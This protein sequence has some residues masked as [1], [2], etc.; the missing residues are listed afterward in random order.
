MRRVVAVMIMVWL[1]WAGSAVASSVGG[2]RVYSTRLPAEGNEALLGVA[3]SADG[4]V[5]V[6]DQADDS[7]IAIAPNG[8]RRLVSLGRGALRDIADRN[9]DV[10]AVGAVYVAPDGSVYVGERGAL[11]RVTAGA[12]QTVRIPSGDYASPGAFALGSDGALWFTEVN[13]PDIGRFDPSTA[14]ITEFADGTGGHRRPA[15]GIA[16]GPDGR[17][18]YT[19]PSYDNDVRGALGAMTTG[20]A[21]RVYRPEVKGLLESAE[22]IVADGGSLWVLGSRFGQAP[23]GQ[24]QSAL[25]RVTPGAGAPAV[26]RV[27]PGLADAAGNLGLAPS[28]TLYAV[29]GALGASG[30]IVSITERGAA[31]HFGHANGQVSLFGSGA[32]TPGVAAAPDGSAWLAADDG[33]LEH[34]VPGAPEPCVVPRVLGYKSAAAKA[35]LRRARCE[36][37]IGTVDGPSDTPAIV[38]AQRTRP[39]TVLAPG[40]PVK[41]TVR[42]GV[43]YACDLTGDG[44]PIL[45]VLRATC[46]SARHLFHVVYNRATTRGTARAD[47]FICRY[48]KRTAIP[49]MGGGEVDCRARNRRHALRLVQMFW[50]PPR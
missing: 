2:G 16:S 14:R 18:W 42:R 48:D 8:Q 9:S 39:D 31:T 15:A 45:K 22:G 25:L 3:V 5:W 26:A 13:R 10:W 49:A 41:L 29:G 37:R 6:S 36:S 19:L 1:C 11:A 33:V 21:P 30:S 27:G 20:G 28:G 4:T 24:L 17:L 34:L 7:V 12:V 32:N 50:A 46:A 47:G 38:T 35:R 40:S 23:A 44:D 43:A